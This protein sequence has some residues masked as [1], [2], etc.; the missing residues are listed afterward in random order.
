MK[1]RRSRTKP[2]LARATSSFAATPRSRCSGD[3]GDAGLSAVAAAD[4]AATRLGLAKWVVSRDNPLTARVTVNRLWQELLG[5]GIVRT[6]DNFGLQG[7]KPTHPELLDWLAS[8][9]MDQRLELETRYQRNRMSATYRQSSMASPA[10]LAQ[11]PEN[12]LLAR[13]PRLRLP[14]ELIRDSALSASGL[15]YPAIGGKS[16]RPPLPDGASVKQ[17]ASTWPESTGRDRYRR[18]LYIVYQRISPYPML[19]N[20]DMPSSYAPACRREDSISPLQ[21]LNLLNDPVFFE[22]AQML[23]LRVMTEAPGKTF[24]ARLDHAFRLTLARLP[25]GDE[26]ALMATSSS[27]RRPL[28]KKAVRPPHR[29]LKQ[30]NLDGSAGRIRMGRSRQ[31]PA[32]PR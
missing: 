28:S 25:D 24:D 19:A 3:P 8:D 21:A 12:R 17:F 9:F 6:S 15:L 2:S 29:C 16:I 26:R 27:G 23:A 22:A 13:Q 30:L 11:D 5:R 1:R 14:A 31:H 20:F 4:A 18:G 7:E 10:L 32:E